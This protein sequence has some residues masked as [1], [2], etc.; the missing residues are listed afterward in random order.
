MGLAIV[1]SDNDETIWQSC[2]SHYGD[3]L[4]ALELRILNKFIKSK[5]PVYQDPDLQQLEVALTKYPEL[6][7][8]INKER[9]QLEMELPDR[10]LR[11]LRA[12]FASDA[13]NRFV[14]PCVSDGWRALDEYV[15]DETGDYHKGWN[16][17]TCSRIA[18]MLIK[19]DAEQVDKQAARLI[20]G[21]LACYK[22]GA[23]AWHC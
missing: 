17:R 3:F 12:V 21:L 10:E 23:F 5:L 22:A 20:D 15:T 2:Y 9:A 7:Y 14:D 8:I 13:V 11:S 18:T 16:S 6:Q 4:G 1:R 19:L